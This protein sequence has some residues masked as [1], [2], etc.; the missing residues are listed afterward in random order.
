MTDNKSTTTDSSQTAGAEKSK[1]AGNDALAKR[2]VLK[3]N[4]KDDKTLYACYMPFVKGCGIFVPTEDDY[5]LGDEVFLLATLPADS[6]K[7][8]VS[9][10]VMWLNPKQ[11]LGKRVPGIGVQILGRDAEKMR[12]KIEEILGKKVKSPLPT[13]TM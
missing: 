11:K 2:G 10:K 13:A 7:F 4:F 5:Q 1:G 6:G 3:L 8:A 9:A 12:D